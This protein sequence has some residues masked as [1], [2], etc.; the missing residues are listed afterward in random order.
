MARKQRKKADNSED[1]LKWII[2]SK[3]EKDLEKSR[4]IIEKIL[5]FRRIEKLYKTYISGINKAV[6]YNQE[7][8]TYFDFKIASTVTGRLSCASYKAGKGKP[9]GVSF[10]TLPKESEFN[11]RSL[12]RA[13]KGYKFIT[14][15]QK[16]MELRV[17]AHVAVEPD[18]IQAFRNK[19]DIHSTTAKGIYGKDSISSQER[20]VGKK[21]AFT[22]VY[23]GTEYNIAE[24][25]KISLEKAT[26]ILDKYKEKFPRVFEY[27]NDVSSF[28][29]KNLYAKTIFNRRRNLPNILSPIKP[30]QAEAIRQGVNFTIQSPASDILLCSAIGIIRDFES[31]NIDGWLPSTVH[32][33]IQLIVKDSYVDK[34]LK[35]LRYHMIEYPIVKDI[36]GMQFMVPF[37]IDVEMGDNFGEGIKV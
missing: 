6:A 15:D 8:K 27:M 31:Q 32:D 3:S 21:V 5:E 34:A 11:I 35:I 1:I 20:Q 4:V 17:L 18:M 12:F 36:F 10:H 25:N 29:K 14:A 13:P 16:T 28:I 23:G 2:S 9:K 37:E 19:E 22:I 26:K 7:E 33:S 24:A 30:I